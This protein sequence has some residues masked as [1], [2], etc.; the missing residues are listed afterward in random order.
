MILI[1]KKQ[2]ID[3]LFVTEGTY[4]YVKGGLSAWIN[5]LINGIPDLN[6][7]VL[8]LGSRKKDYK[9]IQ[10]KLPKNLVY[11]EAIFFF[12]EA[13]YIS[14]KVKRTK[15]FDLL[16]YFLYK[17]SQIPEE[18][19]NLDY[20][21]RELQTTNFVNSPEFSEFVKEIYIELSPDEPFTSFFWTIRNIFIPLFRLVEVSKNILEKK[22]GIVHSPS[23][24]FA[25]FL[26][27]LLKANLNI[28]YILTEHGIYVKERKID[29]L[30]SLE[31]F[32]LTFTPE[33]KYD[34]DFFKELWIDFFINLGKISYLKAD[35]VISLY[36][37]ARKMQID[38]GCPPEK[39]KIIPNGVKI[40][41]FKPLRKIPEGKIPPIIALIARVAPIKDIKTFIKSI[42]ILSQKLPDVEGWIVGPYDEN[43]EYY[44]E[45]LTLRDFLGVKDKVKFLGFQN[46]KTILP[47][48]GLSTLTSISEGMPLVV[49]ESFA[50]GIPFVATNVGSCPQLIYGG[51]N[52]EDKKIGKAGEIAPVGQPEIIAEAYFQLLTNKEKWLNCRENGIKRVEQFYTYDT[53]IENYKKLYL[54]YLNT[55]NLRE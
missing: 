16:K 11:L 31:K 9:G 51:L 1:D 46:I 39:T 28:P 47:K 27:A 41:E 15:K 40:E 6:F 48:V 12:E 18:L 4:P 26:A 44:K 22:I 45:C 7:G 53:F 5:Q 13:Q 20:Y 21:Y 36:E 33:D 25:G 54:K 19:L 52:E 43:P 42:K 50:A 3:V 37:E 49:L 38:L 34:I 32:F 24:G 30:A 8:F 29:I 14:R 55:Y 17:N 2:K 23:T 35:L 10:Y